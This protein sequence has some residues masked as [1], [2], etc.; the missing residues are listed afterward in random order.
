MK[1]GVLFTD[2][3]ET[4]ACSHV[5][6]IVC[7]NTSRLCTVEFTS[8]VA[9][10]QWRLKYLF[11][12]LWSNF[13]SYYVQA[14][15]LLHRSRQAVARWDQSVR[16]LRSWSLIMPWLTTRICRKNWSTFRWYDTDRIE[17][18]VYNNFV[19]ACVL[20]A[21]GTVLL[22]RFLIT[23]V[24]NTHAV[25]E[26]HRQQGDLVSLYLKIGEEHRNKLNI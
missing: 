7:G 10:F 16:W 14:T 9:V 15:L 5:Y 20:F 26:I 24:G 13:S 19:V 25:T 22:R 6:T 1:R 17:N 4:D 18:D 23:I 3:I 8:E 12:H 11:W 2:F 21:A